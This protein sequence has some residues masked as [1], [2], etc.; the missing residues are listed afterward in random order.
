LAIFA[1]THACTVRSKIRRK[2]SAPQRCRMRVSDEWSGSVLVQTVAR[3]PANG[4]V[5]LCL[6]HQPP[7]MDDAEQEPGQHQ[8]HR[9]LGVDAGPAI[10]GAVK[11][12]DLVAQPAQVQHPIYPG[13]DVVVGHEL[14][15]RSIH[16]EL[17]LTAILA[18]QHRQSLH[19]NCLAQ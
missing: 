4:Q 3:E 1:A 18:T 2:R 9:D 16:K 14:P 13:Q 5:D 10:V 11:I 7:V 6:A 12:G 15:E 19:R 17:E 8:P